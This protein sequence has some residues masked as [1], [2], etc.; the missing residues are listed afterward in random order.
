MV[1]RPSLR[2]KFLCSMGS[3]TNVLYGKT[4]SYTKGKRMKKYKPKNLL[5]EAIEATEECLENKWSNEDVEAN[6]VSEYDE[7]ALCGVFTDCS[8][9]PLKQFAKSL[10]NRDCVDIY[11]SWTSHKTRKNARAMRKLLKDM[12][13]WLKAQR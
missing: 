6:I 5:K 12:L 8:Q 3:N 11:F 4:I 9:C 2:Q 1:A 7:C 13:K 10:R